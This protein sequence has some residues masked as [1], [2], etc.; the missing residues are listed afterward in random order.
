MATQTINFPFLAGESGLSLRLRSLS[1]RAIVATE[2]AAE[3]TANN[4]I[5]T[6]AFTDVA[7]GD[8]LLQLI[9]GTDVL[10][11]DVITLTLTT[12][13]FWPA[14]AT[15]ANSSS[16]GLTTEQAAALDRIDAKTGLITGGKL[17]VAGAVT[18]GG[19][20]TLVIGD[21]RVTAADSE[22]LR[23]ISDTGG[24][25]H[26]RLAAASQ[27]KFGAGRNGVADMITGTVVS[28]HASNI[29]TLTIQID[30]VGLSSDASA[31]E[32]YT[33]QIQRVTADGDCVVEVSGNLTLLDRYV[34]R[35]P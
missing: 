31:S 33:Y 24:A 22:L 4:A 6:A 10:G 26:T 18:P 32:D 19:D 27:I 30:Q 2:A 17:S 12:A 9:D 29:T 28:S 8:Y 1:T 23:T 21:D 5:Q 16:G 14:S 7:A 13:Q 35:T 3:L 25:L 34:A 20:I 15:P 11:Q